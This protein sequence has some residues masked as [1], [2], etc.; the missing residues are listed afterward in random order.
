MTKLRLVEFR[1]Q[2]DPMKGDTIPPDWYRK[3]SSAEYFFSRYVEALK[4]ETPSIVKI[5]IYCMDNPPPYLGEVDDKITV[6]YVAPRWNQPESASPAELVEAFS[7]S[8]A[9]GLRTVF[10][11]FDIPDEE[12]Q[13]IAAVSKKMGLDYSLALGKKPTRLNRDTSLRCFVRPLIDL[14]ACVVWLEVFHKKNKVNEVAICTTFPSPETA[15]GGFESLCLE[16]DYVC[17]KFSTSIKLALRV[18]GRLNFDS[19]G[20][21]GVEKILEAGRESPYSPGSITFKIEL[22]KLN[23]AN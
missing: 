21:M 4:I 6:V 18:F 12:I 16:G 15:I 20:M 9:E 7:E 2:G 1:L 17:V 11:W 14:T 13:E 10:N 8:I 3:G 23:A 5:N 19:T 22:A